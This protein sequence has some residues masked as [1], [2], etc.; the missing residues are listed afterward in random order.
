MAKR[1]RSRSRN[2][3]L[4]SVLILMI[5]VGGGY[6]LIQGQNSGNGSD[7]YSYVVAEVGTVVEKALAVGNIEPENEIEVKSKISGV[8]SKIFAEPGQFVKEG[9]PLIEVR[10]DPTPLELAEAK[11]ALEKG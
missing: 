5:A 3:I 9:Q 4:I 10:P 11:R 8:V 1:I 6:F 7:T 2:Q